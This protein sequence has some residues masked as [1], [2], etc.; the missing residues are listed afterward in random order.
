MKDV[1][2]WVRNIVDSR[3][4]SGQV[5]HCESTAFMIAFRRVIVKRQHG[6]Q[7]EVSY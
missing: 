7:E 3:P 2:D 5:V 4:S 6:G 1:K